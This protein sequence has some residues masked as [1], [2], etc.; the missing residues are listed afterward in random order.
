MPAVHGTQL[1]A[2]AWLEKEPASHTAGLTLPAAHTLPSAGQ[3]RQTAAEVPKIAEEGPGEWLDGPSRQLPFLAS[4]DVEQA[5]LDVPQ[6]APDDSD[7]WLD[8]PSR[9]LSQPSPLDLSC[10]ERYGV[11]EPY[12]TDDEG[13]CMDCWDPHQRLPGVVPHRGRWGCN[14]PAGATRYR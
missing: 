9:Q 14:D 11:C 13:N 7:A 4:D 8:G 10:V 2:L 6:I 12:C 3:S 5:A 1:V